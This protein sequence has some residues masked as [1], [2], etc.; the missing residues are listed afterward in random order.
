M[1]TLAQIFKDGQGIWVIAGIALIGLIARFGH[2]KIKTDK[3]LVSRDASEQERTIMKKQIE[4][5]HIA[6][7]A[8]ESKIPRFDHYNEYLGSYIMEKTFDEIVNWIAFNHIQDNEDY[9]SIKQEMIWNII[10][11]E[12][13]NDYIKS[14]HFKKMVDENVE[15]IVK[16][17]VQI[18]ANGTD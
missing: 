14:K 3:I 11:A 12:A 5:A 13:V 2:I 8:F 17:L 10:T 6:C 4:Y 16:R 18:R 15:Q 7:K 9:I 1:D